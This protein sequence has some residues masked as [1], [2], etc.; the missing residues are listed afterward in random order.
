[1]LLGMTLAACN[2]F[3]LSRG[4][5]RP[6]AQ[7]VIDAEMSHDEGDGKEPGAIAKTM[8]EV[9]K[10][11][12]GGGLWKQLTAILLLRLTPVVSIRVEGL[13]VTLPQNV[14]FAYLLGL[15]ML[16]RVQLL[17]VPNFDARVS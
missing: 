3:F 6:L 7:K 15:F 9:Q 12:E 10:A 17:F 2:A 11:I 1:M 5:G 13:A 16:V 14:C 8:A 4:V